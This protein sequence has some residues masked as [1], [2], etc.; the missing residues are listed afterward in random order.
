MSSS[1]IR[2]VTSDKSTKNGNNKDTIYKFPIVGKYLICMRIN[3]NLTKIVD[4]EGYMLEKAGLKEGILKNLYQCICYVIIKSAYG[5]I[6][7][8]YVKELILCVILSVGRIL[9]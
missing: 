7:A 3:Q 6:Y 8:K 9:M 5:H 2:F 4:K 1:K